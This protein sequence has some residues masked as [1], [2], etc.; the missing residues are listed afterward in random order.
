M[1][2]H[3]EKVPFR[4]ILSGIRNPE[5]NGAMTDFEI[6]TQFQGALINYKNNFISMTLDGPFTPGVILSDEID[7]FPTNNLAFADYTFKFTP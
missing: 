3:P 5:F 4:I 2:E 6:S 7:L 1:A